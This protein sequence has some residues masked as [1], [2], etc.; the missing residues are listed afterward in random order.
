MGARGWAALLAFGLAAF[1]AGSAIRQLWGSVRR[2]G[3]RGFVGRTNG[4]MIVH[5]GVVLIA[6]AFAA[7]TTYLQTVEVDLAKGETVSVAGHTVEFLDTTTTGTDRALTVAAQVKVDDGRVFEPRL[8]RFR[9]SGMVVGSPSVRVGPFEDVY[10]ALTSSPEASTSPE[11]NG[12]VDEITIRVVVQPLISW[13]W[14]GGIVMVLGTALALI[15]AK[16]S[17]RDL[18]DGDDGDSAV[19]DDD[20]SVRG[21]AANTDGVA[22]VMG[23][24]SGD[25]S[26][27]DMEVTR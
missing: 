20:N 17:R 10:L 5:L 23:E 19:D 27:D 13:I 15:P 1:A 8:N 9:A 3:V 26:S 16:K 25:E 7:S 2:Q 4:G 11:G 22:E 6:V 24:A 21:E 14:M 12:T 18:D